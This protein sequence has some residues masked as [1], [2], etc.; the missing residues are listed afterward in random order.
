MKKSLLRIFTGLLA[1]V[2][3]FSVVPAQVW[4]AS[5]Y[6]NTHVNTGDQAADIGAIAVS[7]A[8]Y[9]EGSLSGNPS[10]ASSNNY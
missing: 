3:V 6:P 9:C 7:Q 1:M 2:L 8:G 4:A 10:Y 5:A